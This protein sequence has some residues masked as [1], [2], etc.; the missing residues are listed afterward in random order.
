MIAFYLTAE[1]ELGSEGTPPEAAAVPKV[2]GTV[3]AGV[4]QDS[5]A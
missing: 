2:V 4:V 5:R 3:I 1:R